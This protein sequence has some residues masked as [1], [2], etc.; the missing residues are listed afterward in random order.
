MSGDFTPHPK[1]HRTFTFICSLSDPDASVAGVVE[2]PAEEIS[3]AL[4]EDIGDWYRAVRGMRRTEVPP[5]VTSA[6]DALH[7][8]VCGWT[9]WTARQST[10]NDEETQR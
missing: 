5:A 7:D 3:A 2:R 6:L 1:V 9:D 10:T 4:L 8:A